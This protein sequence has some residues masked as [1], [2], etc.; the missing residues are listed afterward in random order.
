MIKFKK[1]ILSLL[2]LSVIAFSGISVVNAEDASVP[3]SPDSYISDKNL[4]IEDVVPKDMDYDLL[5]D[6]E[7]EKDPKAK[8]IKME[9][10]ENAEKNGLVVE[11]IKIYKLTQKKGTKIESSDCTTENVEIA[12]GCSYGSPEYTA[13]STSYRPY[14]YN[15]ATIRQ[16]LETWWEIFNPPSGHVGNYYRLD[17]METWW[18]RTSTSF[19]VKNANLYVDV[20][21]LGWCGSVVSKTIPNGDPWENPGWE[22]TYD[23]YSWIWNTSSLG[24]EPVSV[25][26]LNYIQAVVKADIYYNGALK[27]SK[28]TTAMEPE[29]L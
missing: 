22:T 27:V 8:K 5:S 17:S 26:E 2:S 29:G 24:L 4:S 21:A 10:Q 7:I 20:A 3:N 25:S 16:Y 9:L 18:S 1:L 13:T 28:H 11:S 12:A 14:T 19:T 15:S 6:N 23:S